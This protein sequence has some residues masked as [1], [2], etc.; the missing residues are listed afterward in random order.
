[1]AFFIRGKY[2]KLELSQRHLPAQIKQV[3]SFS[4]YKFPYMF[5]PIYICLISL[6]YFK[7]TC[8]LDHC[9]L[10]LVTVPES[11]KIFIGYIHQARLDFNRHSVGYLV[12]EMGR[13]D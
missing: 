6:K 12:G 11:L 5:N 8:L 10:S 4:T 2:S 13:R 9:K 7:N 3:L 1:M